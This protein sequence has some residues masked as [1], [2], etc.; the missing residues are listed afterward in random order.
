MKTHNAEVC[1]GGNGGD[2]AG[3]S[4]AP[5]PGMQGKGAPPPVFPSMTLILPFFGPGTL[6]IL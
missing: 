2:D 5:G 6:R 3:I 4:K 1:A